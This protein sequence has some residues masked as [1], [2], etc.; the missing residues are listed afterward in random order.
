MD[1][2]ATL[3]PFIDAYRNE[4]SML[5]PF[6]LVARFCRQTCHDQVV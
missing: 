6:E 4:Q 2:L 1:A 3:R 5:F